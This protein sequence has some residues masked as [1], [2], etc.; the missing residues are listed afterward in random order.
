MKKIIALMTSLLLLGAGTGA[1]YAYLTAKEEL[2][3]DFFA[4]NTEIEITEEFHPPGELKPGLTIEKSACVTSR[5]DT[6]CYVRM[7]VRFSSLEAE[8]FCEPLAVL[9]GW[10]P[11]GDG[12]YYWHEP[13]KPQETTGRLFGPVQIRGD[14]AQEELQ[15]FEI[16]VYAEAVACKELSAEE[17][18][19][20]ADGI[21]ASGG[22]SLEGGTV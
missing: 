21:F 20:E 2:T 22:D 19:R 13:L 8:Q 3:N 4:A 9:G 14:A 6:D 5:S 18:W 12:Y 11:G 15:G 10:S 16:L 1:V 17:A 7:S